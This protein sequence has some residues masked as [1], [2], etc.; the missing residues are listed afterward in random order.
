MAARATDMFCNFYLVKNHKIANDLITALRQAK[1]EH[2]FG[3]L[4]NLEHF[5]LTI[6]LNPVKFYIIKKVPMFSDNQLKL[7][8]F[9]TLHGIT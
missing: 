4:T 1:N 5:F 6:F 9:V 8:A 3:I 2:R 7:R